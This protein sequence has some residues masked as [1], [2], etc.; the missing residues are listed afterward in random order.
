MKSKFPQF[1]W[2]AAI[3][4]ALI[5]STVAV[6]TANPD[7]ASVQEDSILYQAV[8]ILTNDV[9]DGSALSAV[10]ETPPAVGRLDLNADGTFSYV[11]PL[12]FNGT[13]SFT[14]RAAG[15]FGPQTFTV[16]QAL[17]SAT[18]NATLDTSV[19]SDS[20]SDTTAVSGT[21]LVNLQPGVA[22]FSQIQVQDVDL[23][24]A[25]SLS[26][27]F[28]LATFFGLEV[29]GVD[30]NAAPGA[31]VL[32]MEIP[33]PAVPVN[34]SGN[35]DQ[36][37]NTIR[38][39]GVANVDGTGLAD[40][41]F[42]E[43][44]IMFDS[45]VP[46][47]EFAG[48]IVESA[49]T[50]T[51]T[52]PVNFDG[53]FI[54]DAETTLTLNVVA[55][56]VAT[57][58]APT[59]PQSSAPTTVTINVTSV[60]DAPSTQPDTFYVSENGTLN[61]A[62]TQ[63]ETE[64]LIPAGSQ[65]RYLDDGSDQG[66]AWTAWNF[67][68]SAWSAGNAKLGYGEGDEGQLI[69]FGG[70]ANNV[71]ITAYFRKAFNVTNAR[72]IS[73]LLL[74]LQRD[75]GAVVYLNG[76]EVARSNMPAVSNA[77]TLASAAVSG[78]NEDTFYDFEIAPTAL[79]EGENVITVEIHQSAI[80]SSDVSFDLELIRTRASGLLANDDDLENNNFAAAL[81]SASPNGTASVAA[82]GSI[83]FTPQSGFTGET[84]FLYNVS[85]QGNLPQALLPRGAKWRYLDDGSDQGTAWRAAA[86]DDSS[87]SIGRAELGYGDNDEATTVGFGGDAG[88]KFAT[89]YFRNEFYISEAMLADLSMEI[90]RDDAAA[91]YLNGV[92]IYR[93]TNL[94][95]AA[96]FNAYATSGTTSETDFILISSPASLL[97]AG[98]NV[99]AV[100]VHQASATSSDLSFDFAVNI[101]IPATTL[102]EN[103][104]NWSYLDNGSD[105][106]T[107]WRSGIF[108]D[109]TWA[110]GPAILG[111][112]EGNEGTVVSF[113][114]N[115]AAKH[116][117]TY[118]R[119]TFQV[120]DSSLIK[121]LRL[122]YLADD[123][124]AIYLNGSE[125]LRNS[126]APAAAFNAFATATALDFDEYAYTSTTIDPSAL[127]NG[128]NT[129]AVE[130]HQ[131]N[132]G[133][134]DLIFDLELAALQT[135]IVG[136]ATVRV[137]DNDTDNDGMSDDYERAFGL[138]VGIND[139]DADI[140][141]DGQSNLAESHAYTNPFSAA[142]VLKVTSI[143]GNMIQFAAVV[144]KTYTLE[145]SPDL[146]NWTP[147]PSASLIAASSMESFTIAPPAIE[148]YWRVATTP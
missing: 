107:A 27:H 51:L 128:E 76:T 20:D 142:S 15:G 139:A 99:V 57:A 59:T 134:S 36:I 130:I 112:G 21:M 104:S 6:P 66:T 110:N 41:E 88:A 12:D 109:T 87:W 11:P 108:D 2:F 83:S 126:L 30:A 42:E 89:T 75:D 86:F 32:T 132:A 25:D 145:Q 85:P 97:V 133:S 70:D 74:R 61:V 143:T 80:N 62:A 77:S 135:V 79:Y 7:S 50:M 114:G 111:Y 14:Y 84:S 124:I 121:G 73:A 60:D 13:D 47:V 123:G 53:V 44:D 148:G 138:I 64:T 10:L 45:L 24:L 54:I 94:P 17:S 127:V 68:D 34:G 120:A 65:W 8:S 43:G 118:F 16:N 122:R 26:L 117:A 69:S 146:K 37:G 144:G 119:K 72:D 96:P 141:G 113:G 33:G 98:R 48:T 46:D 40:G 52:I 19:G 115:A 147:V 67:N 38:M 81:F 91:I 82:D 92:E 31:M 58:P 106:G 137:I 29:A 100:E 90:R 116:P 35:F 49:G 55:T 95:A 3:S 105:Q 129:I 28:T 125:V 23:T 102:V 103:N 39:T 4:T 56:L 101:D 1:V 63:G 93:D 71:H 9:G 5:S 18:V 140:D 78:I 22:P 136:R 131:I